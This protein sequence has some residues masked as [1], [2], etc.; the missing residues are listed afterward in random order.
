MA[1]KKKIEKLTPEQE[2]D[3]EQ[4]RD[5]WLKIGLST[6][7]AD[8]ESAKVV[9]A[10]FYQ[11]L[12]KEKPQFYCL[13]S[14]AACAAKIGEIDGKPPTNYSSSSFFGHTESHW[15]AYYLFAQRIGVEYPEKNSELLRCWATLAKSIG[16][17][18][19]YEGHCF[20]S[21]RPRV[22]R[23]DNEKRLHREDGLAI[24]YSDGWGVAAWHGTRVPREWILD[25]KSL[26]AKTALTWQNV[27]QRRAACEILGWVNVLKELNAK[28][29]DKDEDPG[30]GELVEVEIPEIGREKFL[31]V[32]CGTGREF[33][34]PVPPDMKTALQANSWTFGFDDVRQFLKPEVRT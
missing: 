4:F 23:F 21:D 7:P 26:T 31:R 13:P 1:S 5:E 34:L 17:W 9:I 28:T 11:R 25:K 2:K 10:D 29:I 20:I 30:I 32:L 14:P 27:E 8:F 16:W 22:V 19:P 18:T 3:L 15:I 33:A 24:E 6:E 12:G